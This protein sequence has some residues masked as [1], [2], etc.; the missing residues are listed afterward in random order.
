M[1]SEEP[2]TVA[3]WAV[4]AVGGSRARAAVAQLGLKGAR[5]RHDGGADGTDQEAAAG[6]LGEITN[7]QRDSFHVEG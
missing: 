6:G 2:H 3:K 7:P 1:T 4:A 5:N